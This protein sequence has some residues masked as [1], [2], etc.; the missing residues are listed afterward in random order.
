M[1]SEINISK[2]K[3]FLDKSC[4]KEV[5]KYLLTYR[6]LYKDPRRYHG[7]IKWYH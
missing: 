1:L 6:R 4:K 7:D 3:G 2:V 5:H